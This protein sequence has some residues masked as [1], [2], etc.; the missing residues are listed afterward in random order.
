MGASGDLA[1]TAHLGLVLIGKGEA[2]YGGR[3]ISGAEA[4]KNIGLPP[5]RL[6]AGEGLALI[7]GTQV[8]TAIGALV[9]NDAV[10]LSKMADIACAMTLEVLMGSN[11]EFDPRIHEVRPHPGQRVTAD[12]HAASDCGQ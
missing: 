4:L 9:V 2:F 10:R 8:M 7:N 11:S 5:L 12:N 3:R 1:P 6:A